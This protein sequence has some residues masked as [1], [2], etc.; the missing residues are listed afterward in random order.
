M[1]QQELPIPK[2][3]GALEVV[4]ADGAPVV[5]SPPATTEAAATTKPGG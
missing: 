2:Y 4:G 1:L 5:L 3:T